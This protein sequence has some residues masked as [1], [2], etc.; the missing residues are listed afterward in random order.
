MLRLMIDA[1]AD[2]LI[3]GAGASGLAAAARLTDAGLRVL[4]LE[5]R[6]R[7]GGR[8]HTV[9]NA[10]PTLPIELGAEFVH[11]TPVETWNILRS[12]Q[13]TAYDVTDSHWFLRDGQLSNDAGFWDEIQTVFG[14]LDRVTEPDLSFLDFLLK[15]CADIPSKTREMAL[16]Y[17]EG[18]D[19]ADPGRAGVRAIAQEQKASSEMEE[20]RSFRLLDGYDRVIDLLA[21]HAATGQTIIR[22]NTVAADLR[23]K[24]GAVVVHAKSGDH[25]KQFSA[26]R[27]L[28]TL[29]LGVLKAAENELGALR[30][31]PELPEIR[32]ALGQLEMGSIVKIIFCFRDAFWE[33]Q[34]FPTLPG[35]QTLR[36]ACFLHGRGPK[37]FTWWNFLPLRSNVLVGWSGG[38]QAEKLSHRKPDEVVR[39]ALVCLAQFFGVSAESLAPRLERSMVADWQADPFSRGAYSYMGV[40]GQDAHA[41]LARPIEDT[42]YFAGEATVSGQNGTV[43]GAIASGYRAADQILGRSI[44]T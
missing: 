36:D 20:E 27:A 14:R 44:N 7:I 16:A 37:V 12:G 23:W 2:V 38:P 18:F 34:R 17:I 24:K 42:L 39:E 28:V 43:A 22:L 25:R 30:M 19:A 5:A 41:V 15:Y 31:D 10:H 6:N 33:N 3:I 35:G 40:G 11:G 8:I 21:S 1:H 9:R 26:D 13:L 29:P 4:L 32:H